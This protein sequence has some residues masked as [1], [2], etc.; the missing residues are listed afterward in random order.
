MI[1]EATHE[2]IHRLVE[3]DQEAYG[4][5]GADNQYFK[6]KFQFFPQGILV[7][8]EHGEVT[9]FTVIEFLEANQLPPNFSD[10][11]PA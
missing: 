6:K 4:E 7:V 9:G 2:D 1:R 8:E 5:Y 3:I 11:K 10:F